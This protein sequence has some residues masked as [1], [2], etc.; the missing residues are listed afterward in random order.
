V[1]LIYCFSAASSMLFDVCKGAFPREA[2]KSTLFAKTNSGV[3]PGS[4]GSLP[5]VYQV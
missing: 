5:A 4:S 2:A 3:H 1:V